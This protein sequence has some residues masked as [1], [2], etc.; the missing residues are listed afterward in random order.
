M[1]RWLKSVSLI[2][3]R[4]TDAGNTSKSVCRPTLKLR[5]YNS[6]YF[7]IDFTYTR[8]EHEPNLNV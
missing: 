5:T 7:D 6:D 2:R 8:D 3:K 4:L 1:D